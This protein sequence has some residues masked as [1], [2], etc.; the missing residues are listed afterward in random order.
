MP[1]G[2]KYQYRLNYKVWFAH[3]SIA[4]IQ[5]RDL[6]PVE[7]A[8]RLREAAEEFKRYALAV[9]RDSSVPPEARKL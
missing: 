2:K 5:E 9:E 7:M 1:R 4:S 3:G 6:T 8:A